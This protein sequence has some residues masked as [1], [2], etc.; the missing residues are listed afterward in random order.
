MDLN[1]YQD[2]FSQFLYGGVEITAFQFLNNE[3]DTYRQW[4][5]IWQQYK[6][7]YPALFPLKVGAVASLNK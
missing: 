2:F 5:Q 4:E 3:S 6:E 1:L 7:E